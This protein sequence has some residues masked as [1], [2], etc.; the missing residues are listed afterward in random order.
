M[1]AMEPTRKAAIYA[2]VS[3]P[4]QTPENQLIRLRE[5]AAR[6]GFAVVEE[7]V[8]TASGA[9][10]A[11]AGMQQMMQDANRR[12]FDVLLAWDVSRLGRSMQHLVTLFET[13]RTLGIDL[14]LDRQGFDTTTPAGRMQ[15]QMCAVFAEFE[16][17][18]IAERTRAGLAR[19]VAQGKRLG[20]PPVSGAMVAAI[21]NLRAGGMGMDRIARQLRCGK[22][23]AQRVCQEYDKENAHDDDRQPSG[24]A[25][26]APAG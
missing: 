19:A 9:G 2:R 5:L 3:T 15:M 26:A 23:V 18:I 17:A 1:N 11:R 10:T 24:A 13:L 4:G 20:R 7:Y 8:D 22:G 25:C 14:I 16:R 6:A 12:Q 21:R